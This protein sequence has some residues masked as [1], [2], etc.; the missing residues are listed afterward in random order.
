MAGIL[1]GL[2]LIPASVGV[3]G[4]VSQLVTRR[5][6]EIAIRVS[7]GA[8]GGEVIRL[9]LWQ[10]LRPALFGSIAG[11]AGAV[12][13]STPLYSMVAVPEMPDLTYGAGSFSPAAFGGALALLVALILAA[14]WVPLYR[15]PR[16][17]PA[18]ALRSE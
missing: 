5:R 11:L 4:L 1:G 16:I 17:D 2:A 8:P 7:L 14:S 6:R 10:T 15:A 3:L 13:V 18:E 9:V 12:G